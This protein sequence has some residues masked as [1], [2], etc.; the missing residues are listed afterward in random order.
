ME[1]DE[2]IIAYYSQPETFR[3]HEASNKLRRYTPDFLVIH[4][5]GQRVY[6][7]VKLRKRIDRDATLGGRRARIEM[8]CSARGA[9]FEV[10]TENE[11]RQ[12]TFPR[13]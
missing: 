4:S 13:V 12:N 9:S 2:G 11:I 8:E 10:W 3:W 5:D 7:E 6:R 1:Q